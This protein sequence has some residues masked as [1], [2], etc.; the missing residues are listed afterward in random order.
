MAAQLI[1]MSGFFFRG[2]LRWMASATSSLPVPVSPVIRIVVVV[3]A[4]RVI[5]SKISRVDRL[6]PM[7]P[8]RSMSSGGRS[9][10]FSFRLRVLMALETTFFSSSSSN[11]LVM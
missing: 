8:A 10:S 4:T 9:S 11:G 1:L 2:E 5:A 3:G 6:A 7:M